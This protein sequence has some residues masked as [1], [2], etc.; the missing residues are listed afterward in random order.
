[1]NLL[2]RWPR[3]EARAG[4]LQREPLIGVVEVGR[5]EGADAL[6][7]VR[8]GVRVEMQDGAAA[9]QRAPAIEV[10]LQGLDRRVRLGP[11]ELGQ[12]RQQAGGGGLAGGRPGQLADE[13]VGIGGIEAIWHI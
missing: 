12:R 8:D 5:E 2:G 1:M 10:D 3:L 11:A 6:H 4:D 7:P 13:R 9:R